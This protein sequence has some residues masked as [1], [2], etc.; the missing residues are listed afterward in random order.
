LVAND[1]VAL[2]LDLADTINAS[3]SV[4]KLLA[5]DIAL[6]HKIANEQA[7]KASYES[8]PAIEIKRLRESA[9]MLSCAQQ[10]IL[11]LHK[12]RTGGTQNVIVQHVHV[13]E[14]GQ[15]VI[16]A[17]QTTRETTEK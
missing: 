7:H 10:G 16:G 13:S 6:A 15:A 8:D 12:L 1:I 2:G 4:E 14:G 17:V 3:N 11:T 5:Y 9:R